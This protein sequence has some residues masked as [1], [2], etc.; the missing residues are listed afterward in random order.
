MHPNEALQLL[1]LKGGTVVKALTP[2]LCGRVWMPS[3]GWVCYWFSPLLWEV[4]LLGTPVFPSPQN[5]PTFPNPKL[6][7]NGRQRTLHGCATHCT[8]KLLFIYL[9]ILLWLWTWFLVGCLSHLSL[10]CWPLNYQ[11][12]VYNAKWR[13]KIP[14]EKHQKIFKNNAK[15]KRG[16]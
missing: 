14:K 9:L 15:S 10:L 2:H 4:F 16:G 13:I 8:F 6:T 5:K 7:R 1:H 11:T 12:F 3:V